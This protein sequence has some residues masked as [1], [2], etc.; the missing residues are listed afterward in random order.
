MSRRFV[1]ARRE[2]GSLSREKTIVLALLIQLFVATFSSFLVVGL[3]SL[4]DPGTVQGDGVDLAVA[5]NASG[6]LLAAADD[7][8]DLV[9]YTSTA[10]ASEAFRRGE[11]D[12]VVVARYG[13]PDGRIATRATVP[14]GSLRTTL[15]VT[16][17]RTALEALERAERRRRGA[18]IERRL[19]ALPPAVAA[20]P[21]F[22]FTYTI[23]L[24]L[25]LFL[26][27][28]ISGSIAVDALTE[29]IER[30]TLEL[31]RVTP[32][33]FPEVV[34]AKALV[35][36]VLAP[37]Q[38]ALWMVL[39]ALNGIAIHRPLELLALVTALAV[40]FVAV[41]LGIALS[42]P[43]RQRAQLLYSSA[44]LVVFAAAAFLPEHLATTV[45]L[46]AVGSATTVTH[47]TVAGTAIAGLLVAA[48]VRAG[49]A[50]LDP[51]TL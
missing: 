40:G 30:G 36:V 31:L 49:V 45:A 21:Y 25:L 50:R 27:V 10:G 34:D 15:V 46:L 33:S 16:R 2:L 11:V 41:G 3:A 14:Q 9:G 22:G 43:V 37:A 12:G 7:E 29:E 13:G 24:P 6:A 17:V 26:P 20:S 5:G 44:I 32:L 42:V 8:V 51:A 48:G 1:L 18:F 4:Y 23:L 19:L 28:F 35:A 47:V 38:A 39:L